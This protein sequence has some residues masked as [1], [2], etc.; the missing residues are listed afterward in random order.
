MASS[1]SGGR[2]GDR[3]EGFVAFLRRLFGASGR[4]EEEDAASLHSLP[5]DHEE[6]E[7]LQEQEE[8][9]F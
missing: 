1:G 6:P 9:R 2:P 3:E 8:A 5:S 7:D 4:L